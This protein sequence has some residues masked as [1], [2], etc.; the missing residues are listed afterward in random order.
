MQGRKKFTQ[1]LFY[2]IQLTDLVSHNNFYRRLDNTH[3]SPTDPDAPIS[4]KPGKARKLNYYSQISV[5]TDHQIITQIQ[6]DLADKKDN[7]YLQDLVVNTKQNLKKSGLE[8]E[9]LLAD[10]G[11]SSGENYAWLEKQNIKSYIPPPGTYKGGP[12]GFQF[13]EDDNYWLCPDHKK[14]LF[15]KQVVER[16][17]LKNHYRTSIEDCRNCPLKE[18]CLTQNVH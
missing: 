13:I 6:A 3:Y 15:K 1:K 4:V 9:N 14:V 16:G 18:S 11:Y 12:D 17:T 7:Q 5:D 10:A 8:I 2:Q